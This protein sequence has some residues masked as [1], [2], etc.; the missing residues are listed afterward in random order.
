ML[1]TIDSGNTNC[2]AGLYEGS[3]L[4]AK[5][6]IATDPRRTSDEYVVWLTSLMTLEGIERSAIQGAIVSNVV[7]AAQRAFDRLCR[8]H[9][10][11]E[12]LAVEEAIRSS[13]VPLRV[14]RPEQVG[15]DRIA[16][17]VAAHATYEGALVVIDFGTATT[18]DVID[19]DGGLEGVIIAPGI[20]LSMEALYQA[21][22]R[23][24]RVPLAKPDRI[25]GTDTV[26]AMQSGVYW[27]YVGLIEGLIARIKAERGQDLT[28]VAT[29]G[30]APLFEQSSAEI[31]HDD[32]D[33]TLRGLRLLYEADRMRR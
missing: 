10:G 8:H 12:P 17:A 33:L 14:A 6:R 4:R 23:L 32:P 1:L 3:E 28:T 15:A 20:N 27:G 30:L 16:N 22:A 21:A 18:F 19:P 29:G 25:V 26:S 24:P 5:W 2:V 11:I 7:P 13:D 31:Q 9:L